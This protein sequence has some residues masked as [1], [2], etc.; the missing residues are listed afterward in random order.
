MENNQLDKKYIYKLYGHDDPEEGRV[1]VPSEKVL[2]ELEE[3]S[4]LDRWD[5]PPVIKIRPSKKSI[6]EEEAKK[7]YRRHLKLHAVPYKGLLRGLDFHIMCHVDNVKLA[8]KMCNALNIYVN[9]FRIP[10]KYIGQDG[11][12]TLT[13]TNADFIDDPEFLDII[14]ISYKKIIL[15]RAVT[16]LSESEY[17][18]E[19]A[20]T[21]LTKTKGMVRQYANSE[22]IPIFLELV[23]LFESESEDLRLLGDLQRLNE[24]I[25]HISTLH[26]AAMGSSEKTRD[27]LIESTVYAESILKAYQLLIKYINGNYV[28]RKYI[29]MYIQHVINGQRQLEEMLDKFEITT[30][31]AVEDHKLFKYFNGERNPKRFM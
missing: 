16:E 12:D 13:L 17:V 10:V 20:H 9:P 27:D 14:N 15:N 30:E 19:V 22:I 28:T 5:Q 29:F 25:S 23:D 7:F 11:F 8:A 18:H 3:I 4:S 21:Q 24:L 1:Y 2:S 31:A 26:S 6:V